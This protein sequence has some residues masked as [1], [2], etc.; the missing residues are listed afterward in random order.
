MIE[1][2]WVQTKFFSGDGVGFQFFFRRG[3]PSL[4]EHAYKQCPSVVRVGN[5]LGFQTVPK[6]MLLDI[7]RIHSF[8]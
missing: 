7:S 1:I 2:K 8:S 5:S 6:H 3:T 4:G